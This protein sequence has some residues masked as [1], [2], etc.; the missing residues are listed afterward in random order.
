[1]RVKQF[2]NVQIYPQLVNVLALCGLDLFN[3]Y[4]RTVFNKITKIF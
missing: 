3:L 2:G 4:L 1:M